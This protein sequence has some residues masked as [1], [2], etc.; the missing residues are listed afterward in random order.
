MGLDFRDNLTPV[1]WEL[2]NYSTEIFT[3]E[4][5]R[6][7]EDHN[8]QQWVSKVANQPKCWFQPLFLYMAYQSPHTS[9]G[10]DSLEAPD[11]YIQRFRHIKDPNRRMYAGKSYLTSLLKYSNKIIFDQVYIECKKAG[12]AAMVSAMDDSVGEVMKAL[13]RRGMLDNSIIVFSSDNGGVPEGLEDS[14]GSNWPLRGTKYT[15]WEGGVRASGLVWSPLLQ[16][17]ARK[18]RQLMHIVDWLPTLY[19]A[20]V[21]NFNNKSTTLST[22]REY[23]AGKLGGNVSTL[24]NIDGMD[25]W[26]SLSQNTDSPRKEIL[27]NIDPV[28]GMRALRMGPYKA[29]SGDYQGGRFSGWYGPSGSRDNAHYDVACGA[30][31]YPSPPCMPASYPC[32]FDVESDPCEQNNLAFSQPRV[33]PIYPLSLSLS[34]C[35]LNVL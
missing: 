4:A 29:I 10:V 3:R 20:A 14:A 26:S 13:Q 7:I 8:T 24:G 16:E 19:S 34:L 27:L 25:M 30:R 35:I 2:G 15:L 21:D 6:L 12:V 1:T 18:S 5:V 32:L 23:R 28:W 22:D 11:R 17:P 33:G 9:Y 31:L